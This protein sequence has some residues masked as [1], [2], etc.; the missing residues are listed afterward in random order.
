M[1]YLRFCPHLHLRQ[2]HVRRCLMHTLTCTLLRRVNQSGEGNL[3]HFIVVSRFLSL[4]FKT[5]NFW[6]WSAAAACL[7]VWIFSLLLCLHV[8]EVWEME[9]M[10]GAREDARWLLWNNTVAPI[11]RKLESVAAGAES[12]DVENRRSAA[13]CLSCCF[14]FENEASSVYFSPMRSEN[15]RPGYYLVWAP[16]WVWSCHQPF[17]D[18]QTLVFPQG[19]C[20]FSPW[21]SEKTPPFS[22][23]AS[24]LFLCCSFFSL[25]LQTWNK[26]EGCFYFLKLLTH[27]LLMELRKHGSCT[28]MPQLQKSPGM[29]VYTSICVYTKLTTHTQKAV[30]SFL[31]RFERFPYILTLMGAS[32]LWAQAP[33]R[34]LRT[35]CVICASVST[36]PWKKQQCWAGAVRGGRG[37]CGRCSASLTWT[38]LGS[39]C[40]SPSSAWPC[41][42]TGCVGE[43]VCGCLLKWAFSPASSLQLAVSGNNLLNICKLIFQISRSES[44]DVYFQRSSFVGEHTSAFTYCDFFLLFLFVFFKSVRL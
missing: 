8:S 28:N 27:V 35:A 21:N 25:R 22:S 29:C 3:W 11:L 24:R 19:R 1:W 23:S 42:S 17:G 20:L 36:A 13:V 16:Q 37:S 33:P 5:A 14:S 31:S 6:T 44:N 43:G 9:R 30:F 2:T 38:P 15:T 4:Y 18:A 41:V 34:P 10:A 40:R 39:A 12:G 32:L 26:E 7:Y